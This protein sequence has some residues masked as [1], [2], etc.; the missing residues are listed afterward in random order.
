MK[1]KRNLPSM[2]ER[3]RYIMFEIQGEEKFKKGDVLKA[4]NVTGQRFFGEFEFSRIHPWLIDF[5]PGEQCGIIKTNNHAKG[6]AK[7]ILFL[8]N[9]INNKRARIT[10]KKVSGTLKKVREKS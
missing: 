3:Q 5:I 10:C 4:I 7:S 1:L 8:I 6:E 9:S 2:R